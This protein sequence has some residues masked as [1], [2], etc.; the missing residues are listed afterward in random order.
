[1]NKKGLLLLTAIG[2]SVA[3]TPSANAQ[4][5]KIEITKDKFTDVVTKKTPGIT[6]YPKNQ[7]KGTNIFY[8]KNKVGVPVTIVY[9]SGNDTA[10][11]YSLVVTILGKETNFSSEGCYILFDDGSKISYPT[12]YVHNQEIDKYNLYISTFKI[13]DEEFK[14]LI[15]YKITDIRVG[16]FDSS[17]PDWLSKE[18]MSFAKCLSESI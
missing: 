7:E 10:A 15:Y 1:M 3:H 9:H 18:M 16:S 13:T 8:V 6:I 14:K 4:C 11:G 2:L 12:A 5:E 17:L